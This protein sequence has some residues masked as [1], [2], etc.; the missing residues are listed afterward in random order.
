MTVTGDI[1]CY[2]LGSLPPLEAMDSTVC[3][4]ASIGMSLGMEK[5]NPALTG[6]V[7][8]VIGDSTF[9]HSGITGL[10]DLV[11]NKG[12]GT[13]MVLD[14]STTAMTGH[15]HH[16][17]TGKTLQ[18]EITNVVDIKELAKAIGIKRVV[19]VDPFDLPALEK[20]LREET[21][22]K[23]PSLIIAKRECA[24]IVKPSGLTVEIDGDK[25]VNCKH[26][27]GLGC[28][29]I[30]IREGKVVLN[31]A[32]CTGCNLCVQVCKVSAIKKAGERHA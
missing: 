28:P 20:A 31:A 13:V 11:I 17:A 24:L 3:M 1:G 6:K 4:G 19:E 9:F 22:S 14:N 8:A 27:V 23:Q 10:V 25:C 16:P 18:E 2:T 12:T 29:A 32:I 15:Q 5:A 21:A 26:C 30:A 7:V